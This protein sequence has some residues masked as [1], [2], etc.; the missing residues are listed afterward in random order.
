MRVLCFSMLVTLVTALA[1]LAQNVAPAPQAPAEDLAKVLR[2]WEKAMI[3][4]RSFACDIE[5][6]SF[7]KPL[8]TR[9][10]YTGHAKYMKLNNKEDGI[11]I[12]YKL[13]KVK[14]PEIYDKYVCTGT[15]VYEYAPANNVVRVHK[16]PKGNQAGLPQENILSVLFGLGAEHVK[17]RCKMELDPKAP[18]DGYH[19]ILIRPKSGKDADFTLARLALHRSNHL[20]A[21]IWYVMPNGS[22]MTWN[23]TDLQINEPIPTRFFHPEVPEG[24]RVVPVNAVGMIP[25]KRP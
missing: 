14:N 23:F 12:Y 24:W 13:H 9:D 22:D 16:M 1:G 7:D 21:Q 3:D 8:Q 5:R 4:L 17:A 2:G 10:E 18:K 11:R 25:N 15:D 20:P 6:K 19:Y